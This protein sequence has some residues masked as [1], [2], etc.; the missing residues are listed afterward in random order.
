MQQLTSR[1]TWQEVIHPANVRLTDKGYKKANFNADI[2]SFPENV[3]T[4]K[5]VL[6]L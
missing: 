6:N 5:S 1:Y 3:S 4:W 2:V